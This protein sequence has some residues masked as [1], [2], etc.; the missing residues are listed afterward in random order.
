MPTCQRAVPQFIARS[1]DELG[2]ADLCSAKWSEHN[3]QE[4]MHNLKANRPG[5]ENKVDAPLGVNGSI[6]TRRFSAKL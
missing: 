5:I 6:I 4:W 3:H 1:F 2:V